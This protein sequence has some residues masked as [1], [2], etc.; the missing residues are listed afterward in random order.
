MAVP[1]LVEKAEECG[2]RRSRDEISLRRT[3]LRKN[4]N[5]GKK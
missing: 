4:E 3:A 2:N 1:I 5:A